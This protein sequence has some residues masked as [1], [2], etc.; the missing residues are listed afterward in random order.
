M[1]LQHNPQASR[2]DC[3]SGP[4]INLLLTGDPGDADMTFT[5]DTD[6]STA[7]TFFDRSPEGSVLIS[8]WGEDDQGVPDFST[9]DDILAVTL[10]RSIDGGTSWSPYWNTTKNYEGSLQLDTQNCLWGFMLIDKG[11]Y[12][13]VRV[14]ARS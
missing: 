4:T 7:R 14:R 1:T 3:L 2:I 12:H 8:I 10:M 13:G 11:T 6:A 9:A 5:T